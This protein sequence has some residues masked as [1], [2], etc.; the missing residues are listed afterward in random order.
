MALLAFY[1]LAA[2]LAAPFAER[3][4]RF[5]AAM[6]K[7]D[8]LRLRE[9]LG[10]ASRERPS[11]ALIWLHGAS[12]GESLSLLPLID[13]L[14]QRGANVL[15]TTATVSAAQ[16]LGARLPAGAF[17]QFAPLDAPVFV[18]RFL[19]H[20]RPD[21]AIFAESELWPNM[22]AELK[23]RKTPFIVAN[24][25]IS[26]KSLA[27]W[28]RAP[29][30][31]RTVF[32]AIDACLA[33]DE[34][35][36][37]RF[38][39]LGAPRVAVVGNLKFD[40]A[41]PPVDAARLAEFVAAIGARPVWVAAS[42]HP[43]E[44]DSLLAAHTAL[45]G[46][47]PGLL[48]VFA[49]RH[50]EAAPAI[51]DAAHKRGLAAGLRSRGAKPIRD[52]DIYVADTT[53]ELGLIFRAAAVVFMGKSLADAP[54]GAGGGQNPIEP[55]RLGCVA[56]HGPHVENFRAVYA[57]LAANRA[58][59]EVQD[60]ATLADAVYYLLAEPARLRRMGRA[61]AA[62]VERFGGASRAIMAALEPYLTPRGR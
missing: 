59:I 37:A 29:R 46:R 51:L 56:L 39:A 21:L 9:R 12:L 2:Q 31:A 50:A 17:H 16:T 53:G 28:R 15:V 45:L 58:T 1:R 6:G 8:P 44:I 23:P 10:Q 57:A 4:L 35:N 49:P 18:A 3:A 26:E 43:G 30:A 52:L 13:R 40:V 36:A 60:A 33:Q 41:A 14:I 25:R 7:E 19:D 48:A 61:G 54:T 34:E 5:R 55:A 22:I 62:T 27:R 32:G 20:W 42:I 24:A 11:G 38:A 47:L